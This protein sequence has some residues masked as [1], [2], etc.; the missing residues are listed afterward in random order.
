MKLVHS[1]IVLGLAVAGAAVVACSGSKIA[2]TGSEG[3]TGG[4]TAVNSNDV[5]SVHGAVTLPDGQTISSVT[6]AITSTD[7]TLVDGGLY[8]GDASVS[9]N[10][11]TGT[12]PVGNSNT[13]EFTVGRL[14]KSVNANDYQVT[15]TATTNNNFT[16]FGQAIFSVTAGLTTPVTITNFV[17][18]ATTLAQTTG[19]AA[20][21]AAASINAGCVVLTGVSAEP[22]DILIPIDGAAAFPISIAAS[23]LSS[24]PLT[25][26]V[27]Y[28]WTN[29]NTTVGTLNV[30]TNASTPTFTCKNPGTANIGLTVSL[31]T[32]AAA[33]STCTAGTN[34]LQNPIVITCEGSC[35]YTVCG[36]PPATSCVNI[37]DSDVS[38]C[39]GC[40]VVATT[41]VTGAHAVCNSGVPGYVCNGGTLGGTGSDWVPSGATCVDLNNDVNNCGALAHA[42]TGNATGAT[43]AC[44]AGVCTDLCNVAGDVVCSNVCTN[45]QTDNNNCGTCGTVCPSGQSCTTGA[46]AAPGVQVA[47]N[48]YLAAHPTLGS[49]S[50]TCTGTELALF[51]RDVDTAAPGT[52]LAAAFNAGA[53]DDTLGDGT[54][55]E[56]EDQTL[57]A[58]TTAAECVAEIQ[59]AMGIPS[60][61]TPTSQAAA[62]V[63]TTTTYLAQPYAIKNLFC[64]ADNNATCGALSPA[65]LA[66]GSCTTA[67]LAGLP[68]TDSNSSS[69]GSGSETDGLKPQY[70]SGYANGV[71]LTHLQGNPTAKAACLN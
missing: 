41:T 18:Q 32:D 57:T 6:W 54:L 28:A 67:W 51:E 11:W 71:I 23:E 58:P 33:G 7:G 9:G 46:C 68:A 39:G 1:G 55:N 69:T 50:T 26:V 22:Q 40:G 36:T 56:C 12:V 25:D 24:Q 3:T 37:N 43:Q 30:G 17:C 59:C 19:N 63:H 8:A 10:T 45:T 15:L 42:C 5:G 29:S 35:N 14:P 38:N 64:G 44:T 52:C 70:A 60:T 31:V 4:N 53:L 16:C 61:C 66:P 34:V 65:T 49:V 48:N 62:C 20:I 27:N 21:T 2:S 47:C 13:T